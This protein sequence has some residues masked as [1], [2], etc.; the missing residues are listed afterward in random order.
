MLMSSSN[1]RLTSD[2]LPGNFPAGRLDGHPHGAPPE[3]QIRRVSPAVPLR[4]RRAS[5]AAANEKFSP[6]LPSEPAHPVGGARPGYPSPAEDVLRG[7]VS[8]KLLGLVAKPLGSAL[9]SGL[10]WAQ[11]SSA[12]KGQRARAARTYPTSA[13]PALTAQLNTPPCQKV[14]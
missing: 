13:H 10:I 1:P 11:K 8:L 5:A 4:R 2:V 12:A 3:A 6:E 7:G 14:S 9:P